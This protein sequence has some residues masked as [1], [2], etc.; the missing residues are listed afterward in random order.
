MADPITCLTRALSDGH[1]QEV[2]A[3]HT[4]PVQEGLV[5]S[6]LLHMQ[7]ICVLFD[8]SERS[9]RR[10]I[11]AGHLTPVRVGGALFFDPE[12]IHAL[13]AKRLCR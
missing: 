8:R 10:W 4:S 1:V 2:R 6:R 5:L 13:I 9:I 11:Q 3:D 7:D 12:D